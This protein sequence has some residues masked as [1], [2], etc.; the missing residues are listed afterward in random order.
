[1]P[2][3]IRSCI[4]YNLTLQIVHQRLQRRLKIRTSAHRR[5]ARSDATTRRGAALTT[6]AWAHTPS[7][8]PAVIG[9]LELPNG[10]VVLPT[11]RFG[12]RSDQVVDQA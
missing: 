5:A 12:F 9:L 4:I 6:L 11:R 2:N 7:N 1:M 8:G 10:V 3:K